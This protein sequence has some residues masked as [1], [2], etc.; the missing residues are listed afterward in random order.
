MYDQ[1]SLNTLTSQSTIMHSKAAHD[2]TFSFG[3]GNV[4]STRFAGVTLWRLNSIH[5]P[6]IRCCGNELEIWTIAE[7][8]IWKKLNTYK[9][10]LHTSSVNSHRRD[11]KDFKGSFCDIRFSAI[12]LDIRVTPRQRLKKQGWNITYGLF[13]AL[14]TCRNSVWVS[15]VTH[16]TLVR[17]LRSLINTPTLVLWD[18]LM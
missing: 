4:I 8:S 3:Y 16:W 17:A 11:G 15:R 10:Y 9:F 14:T 13:L 2:N 18:C 1:S 12:I 5:K 6:R 7:A